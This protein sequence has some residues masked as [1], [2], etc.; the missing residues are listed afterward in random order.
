MRVYDASDS[1]Y[2]RLVTLPWHPSYLAAMW[3]IC[4]ELQSLYA[5][6]INDDEVPLMASTMEL[7]REVVISGESP[8]AAGRA[9]ELAVAWERVTDARRAEA[10]GGLLNVLVTF[11]IIAEEIA[12]DRGQHDAADWVTNAARHRW[13]DWD[14]PGPIILNSDEQVDDSSPMAQTLTL[15][16]RIVSEV[17]A[18]HGPEWD[19]TRIRAQILGER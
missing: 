4:G 8:L 13:R 1:I 14:E 3:I 6:W 17:A 19:P 12:L 9:S 18:M 7:V 2:S 16:G 11:E 10:P 15:F 5:P